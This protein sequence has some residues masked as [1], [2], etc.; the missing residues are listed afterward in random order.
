MRG[1]IRLGRIRG[2]RRARHDARDRE[3]AGQPDGIRLPAERPRCD[4]R[5]ARRQRRAAAQR[6]GLLRRAVRRAGAPLPCVPPRAGGAYARPAQLLEDACDGRVAHRLRGGPRVGDRRDGARA[7]MAGARDRRR[8]AVRCARR[9][10]RAPG[11]DRRGDRRAGRDAPAARSR[12]RTRA[13]FVA[14][15]R[16]PA[17]SSGPRSTATRTRRATSS[18]ATTASRRCR[19]GTST[20]ARRICAFRS[21]ADRR[22]GRRFSNGSSRSPSQPGESTAQRRRTNR[23]PDRRDCCP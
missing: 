13:G 7:A 21:A 14:R 15:C 18:R 16:R 6:R 22:R 2:G 11:L 3:H 20:R 5:R 23:G 10:D 17:H 4:R 12:P 1:R 9:A 8:R 19:G